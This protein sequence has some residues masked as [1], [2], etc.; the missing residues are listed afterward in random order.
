[1][2]PALHFEESIKTV[3]CLD[4]KRGVVYNTR[5]SINNHFRPAPHHLKGDALKAIHTRF[6]E[7]PVASSHEVP[8]PDLDSQPVPAIPY[9]K[10][11]R[12]WSCKH[13]RAS[14]GVDLTNAKTHLRQAHHIFGGQEGR[15][16]ENCLLQTI[17]YER[18]LVQYFRVVQ[19]DCEAEN[20]Q[21]PSPWIQTISHCQDGFLSSQIKVLAEIEQ[22]E[23]AEAQRIRSFEGHKARVIPWVKSCGFDTLLDGLDTKE[24]QR[25][26]QPPTNDDDDGVLLTK[27]L[28]VT[29]SLLEETW[30]WCVD[31]PHCRLTRPM[32]VVLSQF[33][34]EAT[35]H[36][37]GFRYAVGSDTKSKYFKLWL[38][39][40]LC[41]WRVKRGHLSDQFATVNDD[42]EDGSDDDNTESEQGQ[43]RQAQSQLFSGTAAQIAHFQLCLEAAADEDEKA[44]RQH[45]IDFNLSLIQ[46]DLPRYRFESPVLTYCAMLA[47]SQN[48]QGWRKPGNFNSSLS[49]MI[50]CAQLWL[51][52]QV[53]EA[54]N[55][56][57]SVSADDL[58]ATTCQRWLR[59]ERSTTY[60]IMLNWR[61]ML[62]DVARKEVSSKNATWSL[63]GSE[64]CYQGTAIR[65]EHISRLY[66]S[67]LARARQIL[68]KDLLLGAD[69]LPRMTASALYES[70]HR[71]DIGWWFG[72]DPRNAAVL[73]DR[74]KQLIEHIHATEALRD[75]FLLENGEWRPSAVRL[76]KHRFQEELECL[77]VLI[78]ILVPPL[79][80]PELLSMTM[81]NTE[82]LRSV[83]LKYA[84]V[85]LYTTYHKGQ[86]QW[87]SYKDNIRFATEAVGN[88]LLDIMVYVL[89]LLKIFEW[90]EG[91]LLSP[92]LFSR[93][94]KV[95]NENGLTRIM[96]KLCALAEVPLL[97][98]SHLRQ[99]CASIIKIKFNRD[100][101]CFQ[102]F[103]QDQDI[104]DGEL[105]END[106]EHEDVAALA[107]MSNHTVRTHNRAYANETGLIGA[108]VWDGLIKQAHRACMLWAIF[109]GYR[110]SDSSLTGSNKRGRAETQGET[111][112]PML[113]KIA[114]SI[115][116]R[117]RHWT[118]HALL[119]QARRLYGDDKLQWRCDEQERA[120]CA[121]ANRQMEV[122]VVMATGGGKSLLFQLLCCLPG[123]RTTVLIV[124]LV[125]LTL[126]LLRRCRDLGIECEQW[127]ENHEARVPLVLMSVEAAV[128][129]DGRAYLY[130]LHYAEQLDLIGIDE[131]HLPLIASEYRRYMSDLPLLRSIPVPFLYLTA[132]LPP[133]KQKELLQQHHLSQVTEIRASTRRHN[134]SY[135]VHRLDS[136]TS[137]MLEHA[138]E[139]IQA[140]KQLCIPADS[141]Q[142][143]IIIFTRTISEANS[144]AS[145]LQCD[146]YHSQIE[147]VEDKARIIARWSDTRGPTFL[148]GTSGL[149]A[150]LDYPHVRSVIHLNEPDGLMEFIQESGR[151]GRDGAGA[152]S[153]VL[154][155]R[156]WR[157]VGGSDANKSALYQFL[158]TTTCRRLSIDK[159]MDGEGT[160][161]SCDKDSNEEICDVCAASESVYTVSEGRT[162]DERRD[163][164]GD[165][166]GLQR[167]DITTATGP[168]LL[169]REQQRE[170]LEMRDYIENLVA[171]QGQCVMC[172][173]RR[174]AWQHDFNACRQVQ[175]WEFINAKRDVMQVT[176]G[177]WIKKYLACFLCAQPQSICSP[178]HG[179]RCVYKDLV[180]PAV[181]GVYLEE[182]Q[183][184]DWLQEEF[185]VRHKGPVALLQW[186]GQADR[187]AGEPCVKGV[188]VL[189]Q[190]M[191]RWDVQLSGK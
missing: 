124:P 90:L 190:L 62:F 40:I 151:A 55:K 74:E 189:A 176:K 181:F 130:R 48:A 177:R 160:E 161:A 168:R 23:T 6:Q 29:Q 19:D 183:G 136:D 77:F 180:M 8:Y 152:L 71:T 57:D 45:V 98:E 185:G 172:R 58:L 99:L 157:G 134:I 12:G 68:D 72:M 86:A 147:S 126:D 112:R 21:D 131:C 78:Q 102:A 41:F 61:L 82:K 35:I 125:V 75:M 26:W 113:K 123:A 92:F 117:H 17:F 150:G 7:W 89:P 11:H 169:L 59:Q 34:T 37:K 156:Q 105:N 25:S 104:E 118:G 141:C 96:R 10:V 32:A 127:R 60:G 167:L 65:M 50:Y 133:P 3:I 114:M 70:E 53:C 85:M 179:A 13:C 138:V 145:L 143:K 170:Q 79:R 87:G 191:R 103:T 158:Q 155:R 15:D 121:I 128:S 83:L 27:T 144:L 146:S 140:Q 24:I 101:R 159:Y 2:L 69:R 135:R 122:L 175:K 108:N 64:V 93:D 149:G 28:Q 142:H 162:S 178:D 56:D 119:E 51:F 120:M 129:E 173:I 166:N 76:Y 115:P 43:A 9:L 132:T 46:H 33:W 73:Q 31:G 154:L 18:R 109:F 182:Q 1:M 139:F 84:L 49:G 54:V 94:G 88:L 22:A 148:V 14:L 16:L 20:G 163:E 111:S 4:C 188:K 81:W 91:R 110:A 67:T 5:N 165:G 38:D 164:P 106:G 39:S 174:L 107:R 95:W 42:T 44:L 153:T 66:D 97:S 100:Q 52:R 47:V 186:A 36:S 171:M 137:R 80:G 116:H 30:R 187:F 63:D 184:M